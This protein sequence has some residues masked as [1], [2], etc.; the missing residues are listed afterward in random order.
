M[1]SIIFN[2]H[3]VLSFVLKQHVKY[4][5]TQKVQNYKNLKFYWVDGN[6]KKKEKQI[7]NKVVVIDF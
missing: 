2:T 4:L 1:K 7:C 5:G 6:E 3:E